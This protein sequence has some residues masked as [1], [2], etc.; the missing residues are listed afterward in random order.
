MTYMSI[1]QDFLQNNLK[2]ESKKSKRGGPP[3][4]MN[5]LSYSDWMKFQ[6]SFFR[7]DSDQKLVDDCIAFFTKSLWPSGKPSRT[8]I[9]GFPVF[10]T[11]SIGSPRV[12][13]HEPHT[14]ALQVVQNKI[15]TLAKN[16]ERFDFIILD[17][18]HLFVDAKALDD[19]IADDPFKIF[20]LVRDLLIDERYCCFVIPSE[21]SGGG[22]FP[23]AW[24]V[25][26]CARDYLRLRDEK[27]GLIEAEDRIFYCL[28]MQAKDDER[29]CKR[30]TTKN[31]RCK[32][33]KIKIPGWLLPK[34]PPRKANEV[35]HPAKFP[36]TLVDAFLQVFSKPGDNILDP[37]VGTGSTIVAAVQAQRNGYGIELN[38]DFAKIAQ[39]RVGEALG[40]TNNL[41]SSN[42][43]AVNG[44]VIQGDATKLSNISEINKTVFD[45]V[46]TS[47]PYWS[48]L[49][50][51][52][53]EN[54]KKRRESGLKLTY[55]EN[56]ADVG[57]VE[58]YDCF[59][60][61]LNNVYLQVSQVLRSGGV[62]TVVVKNVKRNHILYPL[63]WDLVE[64][65]ASKNAPYEYIGTTFWCQDNVG[66]KPFAVGIHWVS[67]ILHH[68]CLHFRRRKIKPN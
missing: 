29:P 2:Q 54:Q 23:V 6:K 7:Y 32:T 25:A 51:P 46:I 36:E 45:Y 56:E 43:N 61:L 11:S 39:T 10:K 57:N 66:L 13:I 38:H 4:R 41:F 67:N 49:S 44:F 40:C 55:S 37:M 30:L 21:E 42:H 33:T 52:G 15:E 65:L 34:P 19:F 48:M 8:L 47:P 17:F 35:L 16:K 20:S 53:S 27:I 14:S 26:Q 28:F 5:D 64:L 31:I 68:Y 58:D 24:S 60:T 3:N 63:A 18:R 9:T 59:L 50:N 12:L 1:Q 62:L 22:G